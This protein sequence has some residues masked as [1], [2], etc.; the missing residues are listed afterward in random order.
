MP[1]VVI[2]VEEV[3]P[4]ALGG[5]VLTLVAQTPLSEATRCVP[6]FLEYLGHR[7]VLREKRDS[8][9]VSSDGRMSLVVAR[10]QGAAGR[11]TDCIPRITIGEAN[12]LLG[13]AV[14]V[15]RED[16]LAA[17]ATQIVVAH[18][19]HHYEDQI[20]QLGDG[21]SL[22]DSEKNHPGEKYFRQAIGDC[23]HLERKT[24]LLTTKWM[25]S[26]R[27][28]SFF[29]ASATIRSTSPRSTDSRC[30]PVA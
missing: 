27:R 28:F 26:R 21:F 19:V 4:L 29:S 8:A 22:E 13:H 20:G 11:G 5:P 9:R 18:V 1:L 16:G 15:R 14:E 10:H 6:G 2:A 3:E 7:D 25:R 24:S 23:I 12:A 30:R 17:V